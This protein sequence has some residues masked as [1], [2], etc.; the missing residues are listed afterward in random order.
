MGRGLM[1][2]ATIVA[3]VAGAMVVTGAAHGD[4]ATRAAK[5]P[6]PTAG[7][8]SAF[9]GPLLV[10]GVA[11]SGKGFVAVGYEQDSS[12]HRHAVVWTEAKA[13]DDWTRLA[14]DAF[15][16]GNPIGP[17]DNGQVV[18]TAMHTVAVGADGMVA[19]GDYQLKFEDESNGSTSTTILPAVW[20]SADGSG[21]SR[22]EL[23]PPEGSGTG[24]VISVTQRDGR[25]VA[26]GIVGDT[27]LGSD[28]DRAAA[29]YSDDG[30]T[31]TNAPSITESSSGRANASS[32]AAA[33]S[34]VSP[35]Y[36]AVGSA[37]DES[38]DGQSAAVWVSDDGATWSQVAEQ[39]AFGTTSKLNQAMRSVIAVGDDA[40]FKAVGDEA[41]NEKNAASRAVLWQSDDGTT[42]T[43]STT[44]KAFAPNVKKLTSTAPFTVAVGPGYYV[45]GGYQSRPGDVGAQ[46]R[47]WYSTDFERWTRLTFNDGSGQAGGGIFG[48]DTNGKDYVFVG[49]LGA[50]GNTWDGEADTK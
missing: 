42:W 26:V 47:A 11:E 39:P 37:I 19:G 3:L 5:S 13:G 22:A 38:G 24:Q 31:W 40:S 36:V 8:E 17:D 29:W 10:G 14:D 4:A 16:D 33:G 12:A 1:Q 41:P 34:G 23:S 35:Q 27:D 32:V 20:F 28:A 50:N 46:P 44:P 18:E 43:R 45:V 2:R 30:T 6:Q 15:A 9:N 48:A 25:F 7:F 49:R 21:W